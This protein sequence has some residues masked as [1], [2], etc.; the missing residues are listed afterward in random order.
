MYP[1]LE[2][3]RLQNGA[4][5]N[6]SYHEQRM[7]QSCLEVLKSSPKFSLDTLLDAS[8]P[9]ESGLYKCRVLYDTE[10]AM[11]EFNPYVISPIRRLKAIH[12]DTIKYPYKFSDRSQLKELFDKREDCDDILIIKNGLI[13]DTSYANI[14]FYQQGTWI[15][16]SRP[17]LKG[18]MRQLLLDRGEIKEETISLE[19]LRKFQFFK[20]MNA[21]VEFSMPAQPVSQII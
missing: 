13:T 15:T 7:L 6:L 3:I 4:F 18:T 19:G 5:F 14:A 12:C 21:M 20:I 10:N 1:L 17:L 9:P 2:T 8:N 16:P 11:I